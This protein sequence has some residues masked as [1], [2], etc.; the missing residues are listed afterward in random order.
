MLRGPV[1]VAGTAASTMICRCL[2]PVHWLLLVRQYP[3]PKLPQLSTESS[4]HAITF[5]SDLV[6]TW[7]IP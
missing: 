3:Q 6:L 5:L 2:A 1:I 4:K 7:K